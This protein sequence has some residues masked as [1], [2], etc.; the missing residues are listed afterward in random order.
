MQK[1]KFLMNMGPFQFITLIF[2]LIFHIH[3]AQASDL[4]P[5][6]EST[7]KSNSKIYIIHVRQPEGRLF[8]KTEDLES[9]Y[10]SFMPPTTMSSKEQPRVI[11]SYHHV[12]KG[13][14]ARLT[15]EELRAV[16]KKNGFISAHPER[17]LHHQTTHTPQFLGL[18]QPNGLW[19]ESNFGKGVIIGVLDTGV[20]PDHPSFS[21]AGIP[22]PPPK[23]KGRCEL[24]GT[25]CNNKL[26][27][28]RSLN[29]AGYA[30]T[31]EPPIDEDGHGTHTASTA[32]GAFVDNAEVLGNAKGTAVGT[33]PYAHLSIYKVCFG[34]DCPE[35]NILAAIDAAVEDGVDVLSLSLGVDTPLPFFN[36]NIAIGAFA[37]TQK[38]IL[39]SCAAG[40]S[41]PYMGSI[42]NG[43]P[44]ILT[45]GASTT[46]RSIV[47]T[48]KLGDGQ[49]F[50]GESVFQPSNFSQTLL[51][52]A[53]AGK[54]GK[55]KSAACAR[56][57]LSDI[58]FRGKVV[59]CERGGVMGR[60]EKGEEV[61]RVGGVAM[62]IINDEIDGF[63]LMADVH[64]LPATH[65]SYAAGL[66]IKAYINSTATPTATIL[67][68]GTT[69]GNTLAPAVTS[70]SSR[71]P[72]LQSPG[73]LKPD[74]IGPGANILAAS[75]FPVDNRINSKSNFNIMSGT[76]MACPHISGIAA[77]L[78][79]SHPD[80][81]PAAI[82]SAMMTSADLLHLG[83]KQIVDETLKPAD[84]FA[85]GSGHVNPS[86]AN[87]PG[88]VYDI[89]L[90]DYIPYLCGLG[91]SDRQVGMIAQRT[92]KCTEK[93]SIPEG[94]LNYP[95]FS[96]VLGP[97]LQTFTRTVT[98]VGE[99]YSSYTA[100]VTAPEGVEVKVHPIY[101]YFSEVNQ[102]KTYSVTF[103]RIGLGNK[104][105]EYSQGFLK[106]VSF[107]RIVRSPISVIFE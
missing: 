86:R 75:P 37:A 12:M 87:D 90:G 45:V 20:M 46:D 66:R 61:K 39:V 50:Y 104:T 9:W 35:S 3:F 71:G 48:A 28:A 64:V 62:I 14:A 31:A 19:Q 74:I 99:P 8:S 55:Q 25:A 24:N 92:I 23:W 32:A 60:I 91:Y 22:P 59:L 77:L 63:S 47:A 49:E 93:S 65:V 17:M 15:P 89:E 38:G 96:V 76:S 72:N 107:H 54:N 83:L 78:K 11:H 82:K 30:M 101:L 105:M 103:N 88:L 18:W 106:W 70:F 84:L 44:W 13:F 42:I 57:Y 5:T 68:K 41:G 98:N 102:K 67:F 94:E 95:S 58:D 43:A 97:S 16:E 100:I 34:H 80:W 85:M 52:L 53:Y 4:P 29:I 2:M 79:S 27:G 36:D 26:I 56:G 6:T 10:R 1:L 21:D 33:A 40:N 69:L 51:P 81:S 7:L 73:I